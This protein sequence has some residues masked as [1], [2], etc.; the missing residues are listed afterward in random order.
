MAKFEVGDR[1]RHKKCHEITGEILS[2]N[3]KL[4]CADVRVYGTD[5]RGEQ[6]W[7]VCLDNWEKIKSKGKV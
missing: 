1:I 6:L 3:K 7:F 2:L 5:Y 4:D